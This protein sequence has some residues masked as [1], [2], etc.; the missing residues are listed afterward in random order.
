[1][2]RGL[3]RSGGPRGGGGVSGREAPRRDLSVPGAGAG[4]RG[5]RGGALCVCVCVCDATRG[6][7]G[8]RYE[9]GTLGVWGSPENGVEAPE[10]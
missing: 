10:S 6:W 7:G 1:M 8:L 5:L 2:R 4:V 3:R 9:K